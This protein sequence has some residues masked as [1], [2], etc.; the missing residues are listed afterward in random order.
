VVTLGM[1]SAS[2]TAKTPL[3][4]TV[5]FFNYGL[6]TGYGAHTLLSTT[7]APYFQTSAVENAA[8]N[9][10][11]QNPTLS[12]FV[13]PTT[14]TATGLIA[15]SDQFVNNREAAWLQANH[16]LTTGTAAAA[17]R[18]DALTLNIGQ[19]CAFIQNTSWAQVDPL[20]L[21]PNASVALLSSGFN[22]II[23]A[24]RTMHTFTPMGGGY[25]PDNL[26]ASTLASYGQPYGAPGS[27][28]PVRNAYSTIFQQGAPA[29]PSFS[30]P[31]GQQP[32][33]IY[34]PIEPLG[35]GPLDYG[36]SSNSMFRSPAD[37][38]MTLGL[39]G[40]TSE[41][42]PV[43][44]TTTTANGGVVGPQTGTAG[45]YAYLGQPNVWSVYPTPLSVRVFNASHVNWGGLQAAAGNRPQ[46]LTVIT[47]N[48]GYIWGD[49]NTQP[50]PDSSGNQ[51]ITPCAVFCDGL[52]TLSN[53]WIDDNPAN[54]P[55]HVYT[56]ATTQAS[57]TTYIVSVVINNLPTD[58]ENTSQEGSDGTHNVIRY[59]ENWGGC[60]WTFQGS[61]VVLNRMRYTRSYVPGT[62]ASS[63]TSPFTIPVSY[64]Q[65]PS[66][67]YS[68][69]TAGSFYGVPARV[70][71][72]N[73]DLLTSAG[74]PPA[75]L[76]GVQTERVISTV[77]LINK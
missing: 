9:G 48:T 71:K 4:I 31:A 27:T 63:G 23:Y 22:G 64:N 19:I 7:I 14:V 69:T 33:P 46:G 62:P 25:P 5:P 36:W 54:P 6:G 49:Y 44:G 35:T 45:T 60:T 40:S 8:F 65:T 3:D 29:S 21:T 43:I 47:P 11:V 28:Y 67:A 59:A 42:Y 10:P 13:G 76:S 73:S 16:Y 72:F 30:F 26:P 74:Q 51:Q 41:M 58:L 34:D 20:G 61:L 66:V 39:G 38:P 53:L 77:N 18:V 52:T 1:Q 15:T 32:L 24:H 37:L 17:W 75:S 2:G 12:T 55:A 50:Y 56:S 68:N 57:S 70:Y